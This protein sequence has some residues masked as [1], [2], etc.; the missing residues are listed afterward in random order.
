VPQSCSGSN[1]VQI[2]KF[3]HFHPPSTCTTTFIY[4]IFSIASVQMSSGRGGRPSG[5][6]NKPGHAAGGSRAGAG[7]KP[8]GGGNTSARAGSSS[9]SHTPHPSSVF[10]FFMTFLSLLNYCSFIV[11]NFLGVYFVHSYS[12]SF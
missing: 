2:S 10:S 8:R 12:S 4:F 3:F 7:R 5:T 6:V 9:Q 1:G 11:Q